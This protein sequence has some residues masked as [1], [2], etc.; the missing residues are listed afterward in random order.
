[1]KY[2]FL[3]HTADLAVEFSGDSLEK[4]LI[5]S[6]ISLSEIIFETE[7]ENNQKEKEKIHL[8]FSENNFTE[9]YINLLREILFQINI[10]YR[11][12]YKIE[13]NKFSS[14]KI[15]LDYFFYSMNISDIKN[16]IKAVTYHNLK[17]YKKNGSLREIKSNN[18]A[19]INISQDSPREMKSKNL[20]QSNISQG[21]YF[22]KVIFDI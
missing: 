6:G 19:Q 5:N 18:L 10:N 3:N 22:A 21:K 2:K 4:L 20:I 12:I 15:A 13:I 8:E 16:E 14:T 9:I 7:M 11:F 1:M 17:I